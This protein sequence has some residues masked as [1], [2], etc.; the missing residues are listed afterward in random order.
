MI[1]FVR[2]NRAVRPS[3]SG[4]MTGRQNFYTCI[5]CRQGY[6]GIAEGRMEGEVIV[7]DPE[8]MGKGKMAA[9]NKLGRKVMDTGWKDRDIPVTEKK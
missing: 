4:L 6:I 8:A 7:V 9:G 1:I 5:D 3:C 2:D